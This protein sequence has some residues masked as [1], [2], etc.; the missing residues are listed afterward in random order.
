MPNFRLE[1]VLTLECT[2]A[3]K[4]LEDQERRAVLQEL[5]ERVKELR[6]D[7]KSNPEEISKLVQQ[8]QQIEAMKVDEVRFYG[9]DGRSNY[10]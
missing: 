9:S 6:S 2:A 10:F 1:G 8:A 4:K 7:P 5:K 3:D